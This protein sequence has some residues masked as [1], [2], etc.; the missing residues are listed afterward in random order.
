[1]LKVASE[2]AEQQKMVKEQ[3]KAAEYVQQFLLQQKVMI[4]E[5]SFWLQ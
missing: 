3:E 5:K 4:S 1:M 2:Q